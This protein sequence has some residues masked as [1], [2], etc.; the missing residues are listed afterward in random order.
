MTSRRI[1]RSGVILSCPLVLGHFLR[2]NAVDFGVKMLRFDLFNNLGQHYSQSEVKNKVNNTLIFG[3]NTEWK[4][5]I[6]RRNDDIEMTLRWHWDDIEMISLKEMF[7]TQESIYNSS[8]SQFHDWSRI[9]AFHHFL[10]N[11]LKLRT[12]PQ[13]MY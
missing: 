7:I 10:I 1:S 5:I 6:V 11:F 12:N 4:N 2:L 8:H 3:E 13:F 9:T